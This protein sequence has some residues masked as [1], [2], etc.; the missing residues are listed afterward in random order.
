MMALNADAP[1]RPLDV[2]VIESDA[3]SIRVGWL[4]PNDDR[5]PILQYVVQYHQDTGS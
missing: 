1:G 2:R 3:R 4:A 5:T